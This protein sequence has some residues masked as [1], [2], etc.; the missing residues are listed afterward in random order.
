[1]TPQDLAHSEAHELTREDHDLLDDVV[2]V[3]AEAYMRWL[4]T[5]VGSDPCE[6]AFSK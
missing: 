1:M 2:Q 4:E 6:V 3:D 5:G